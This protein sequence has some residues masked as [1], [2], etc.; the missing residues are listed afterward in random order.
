MI[1]KLL[2]LTNTTLREVA[3]VPRREV[4]GVFFLLL[5]L[6]DVTRAQPAK[7]SRGRAR[8][9]HCP[10]HQFFAVA[11]LLSLGGGDSDAAGS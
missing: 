7:G 3:G 2:P 5:F 1:R 4:V 10:T 9:K 6:P 11:T 8:R